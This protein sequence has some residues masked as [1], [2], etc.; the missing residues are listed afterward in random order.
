MIEQHNN[1][2]IFRDVVDDNNLIDFSYMGIYGTEEQI[3]SLTELDNGFLLGDAI[4]YDY[5][6]NHYRR[7]LAMNQIMSE[8]I[9]VVSKLIDKDSFELTLKGSIILDRYNNIPENTPLYL[10]Q[11]ISG[12]LVQD[13]PSLVSKIIGITRTN[14]IYV[15]IQRGYFVGFGPAVFFASSEP[16]M[17]VSSDNKLFQ[18][19]NNMKDNTNYEAVDKLRYY[20]SQEIQDLITRIKNDIY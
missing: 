1:S 11:N 10:S 15:N 16:Y 17:F 19:A 2:V 4:Y 7:A 9:G 12:K 3:I 18:T 8:V 14:G 20:T 13:E 6:T 5:K